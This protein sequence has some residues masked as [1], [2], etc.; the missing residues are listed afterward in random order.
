ML[1][2]VLPWVLHRFGVLGSMCYFF[3]LCYCMCMWLPKNELRYAT[4]TSACGLRL[5]VHRILAATVIANPTRTLFPIQTVH[6]NVQSSHVLV[7]LTKDTLCCA[8]RSL[9]PCAPSTHLQKACTW[10]RSVQIPCVLNSACLRRRPLR[11][12]RAVGCTGRGSLRL[13]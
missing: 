12:R 9:H 5:R 11:L 8:P 1:P 10:A 6:S 13:E 3:F 7:K 2:W 4:S